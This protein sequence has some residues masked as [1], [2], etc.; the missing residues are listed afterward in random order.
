MNHRAAAKTHFRRSMIKNYGRAPSIRETDNIR[1]A[2]KNRQCFLSQDCGD[3]IRGI[4]HF[5]NIYISVVYS[6]TLDGM[7][8][9]G[10]PL[11]GGRR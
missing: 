6:K 9:A 11:T 3:T 8:T 4:V 5:G 2:L 7:L 10:C 1:L